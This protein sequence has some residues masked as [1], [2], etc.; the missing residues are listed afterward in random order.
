MTKGLAAAVWAIQALA[1]AGSEPAAAR[2]VGHGA[3]AARLG[4]AN[5]TL[6][7]PNVIGDNMVL[8]RDVPLPIWGWAAPGQK[9][10]VV[11]AGANAEA[12][13]DDQGE[14]M[15][16]LSPLKAGGPHEMTVSSPRSPT[17]TV[18]NILVGEV[19]LSSGQSNMDVPV[20]AA[21][22]GVEEV[23]AADWPEIRLFQPPHA[24]RG[25][26][27]VE[28]SAEW[29]P[30]TPT[31][32]PNF[33]A[34]AYYFGRQIHKELKVPVGLI[35]ASWGSTTVQQWTPP[36]GYRLVEGFASG[37]LKRE[38]CPIGKGGCGGMYNGMIAPVIPFAIRGGLWYQG[39]D[40]VHR[41]AGVYDKLLE[42]LILGWRDVWGQG[43][44]PVYFVQL[45]PFSGTRGALPAFWEA[46]TR[47]L[48]IP[49]TGMVVVS[50]LVTNLGDIHP[51]NK[52]DVGKRLAGWA[53]AKDY[54]RKDVAYCGPIFK[55]ISIEGNEAMVS[56]DH[57]GGG[58]AS[59]DGKDL[60]EFQVAGE[61]KKF[62]PATAKIV[63]EKVVVSAEGVKPVAVR[64][65]YDGTA[66][67]NLMNKEGLPANSFRT[68]NW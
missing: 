35:N 21:Q 20:V 55:S 53:L 19:W 31:S 23:A 15:V 66:R 58:L 57:A 32:V 8:Q 64:F 36:E 6:K 68:D 33:S 2:R 9:V 51:A 29:R 48:R 60:T 63:G 46:Q 42:A 12:I 47:A 39:E 17:L 16:T 13:A 43:A 24:A 67:G 26:P 50:D 11:L 5:V 62:A 54:G 30:C 10:S 37:K 14:W 49:N 25:T 52:A 61:D 45:A 28:V 3:M 22:G 34:V 44:F 56:F 7:L 41:E 1:A 4:A 27:A 18:K 59:R 65:A 40:N 38:T